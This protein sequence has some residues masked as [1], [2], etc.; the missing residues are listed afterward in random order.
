MACSKV[1][2]SSSRGQHIQTVATS[3]SVFKTEPIFKLIENELER[4]G[5]TYV[6]KIKGVFCFKVKGSGG[7][8][9]TWIVDA[10]NGNGAVRID[11]KGKG[12]VTITIADADLLNLMM[13]KLNPQQAFFQ[14][15]LKIAGNMGLAMKL[16][17]LQP[18]DL[19]AKL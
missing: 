12:D 10:K 15:K 19:K 18:K 6:K 1:C 8:I 17:D 4:D 13:G 3:S 2:F 7:D 14:G 5:A 16:K 11:D 9:R